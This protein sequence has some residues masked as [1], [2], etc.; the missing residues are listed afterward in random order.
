M[1]WKAVLLV[2]AV[3]FASG[4][5][6]FAISLNTPKLSRLGTSER[7]ASDTSIDWGD[8]VGGGGGPH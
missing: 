3:F 7:M 6:A 5:T 2:F 1:N 4:V 8:A